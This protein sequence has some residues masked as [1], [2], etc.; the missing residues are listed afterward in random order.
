MNP[1]GFRKLSIWC[2]R[3]FNYTVCITSEAPVGHTGDVHSGRSL[4]P[5]AGNFF[6]IHMEGVGK[7]LQAILH[8]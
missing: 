5:S 1:K 8:L 7:H 6:E 2:A 3:L 4:P